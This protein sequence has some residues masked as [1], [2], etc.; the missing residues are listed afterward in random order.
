V[1]SATGYA[2][3]LHAVKSW[4]LSSTA[5]STAQPALQGAPPLPQS[6]GLHAPVLTAPPV[7]LQSAM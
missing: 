2:T 5:D 3:L 1:S 7:A 4:L 6:T